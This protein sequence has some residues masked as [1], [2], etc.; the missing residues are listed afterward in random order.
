MH[1]EQASYE[2]KKY[3]GATTTTTT[4]IAA[5]AAAKKQ[6]VENCVC[7]DLLLVTTVL[8]RTLCRS[9]RIIGVYYT[10]THCVYE[11]HDK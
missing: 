5:A 1:V 7:F 4:T 10:D 8:K 9:H 3:T 2:E 6:V 11:N